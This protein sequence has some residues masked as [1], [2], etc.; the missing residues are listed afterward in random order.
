MAAPQG[1]SRAQLRAEDRIAAI[2]SSSTRRKASKRQPDQVA[3]IYQEMLVEATASSE[4][5]RPSPRPLKKRRLDAEPHVTARRSAQGSSSKP[6]WTTGTA[7]ASVHHP[8]TEAID[9]QWPLQ[10]VED[11]GSS[12]GEDLDWEE[13]GFDQNEPIVTTTNVKSDDDAIADI[14]V[15]VGPKKTPKK[16]LA[17]RKPATTVEKLLRLAVH[18]AHVLFLIF[19]LHVRNSWCSLDIVHVCHPID[20]RFVLY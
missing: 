9:Q 4:S 20:H 10:T 12:E 3:D 18:E 8:G 14:S 5:E 7:A 16:T 1:K 19:H 11:S 17:K 15:E 2:R 13:V 6:D